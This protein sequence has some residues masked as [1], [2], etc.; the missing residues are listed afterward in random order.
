M[1]LKQQDTEASNSSYVSTGDSSAFIELSIR[2][3]IK[4]SFSF[5]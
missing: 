5:R 3:F 4:Y 2:R 1:S